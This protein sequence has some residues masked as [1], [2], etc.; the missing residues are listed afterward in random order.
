MK[1]L[2]YQ[3][4]LAEILPTGAG[5]AFSHPIRQPGKSLVTA[6]FAEL[7]R[8]VM[9][10]A[11]TLLKWKTQPKGGFISDTR[12]GRPATF[13][14]SG[15]MAAR[16]VADVSFTPYRAKHGQHGPLT[17]QVTQPSVTEEERAKHGTW[18]WRTLTA[19]AANLDEAKQMA[20]LWFIN[21]PDWVH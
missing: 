15:N 10:Q 2:P 14:K 13:V 18:R 17:I 5:V 6:D 20:A 19:R 7:E 11:A 9:A 4:Y 21:H 12:G 1:L 8:R 3:K 16:I